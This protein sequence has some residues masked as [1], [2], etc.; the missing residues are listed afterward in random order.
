MEIEAKILE[1]DVKAVERRLQALGA[2]VTFDG[3]HEAY[4]FDDERRSI[5]AAKSLL[6]LR[7]EIDHGEERVTFTFKQKAGGKNVKRAVEHETIVESFAQARK[8]LEGL[9]LRVTRVVRKR[10]REYSLGRTHY[11]FDTFKG[12]PTFLEIESAS[13]SAVVAAARQLGFSR[14]DLKPWTGVDVLKHYGVKS[15]S[16]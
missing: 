14:N 16:T 1:V 12:V 2:K 8:I 4:A 5:R 15:S 7:R 9:G 13:E 3:A 6:R 10:R 11:C